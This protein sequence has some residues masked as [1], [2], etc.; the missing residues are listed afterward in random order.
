VQACS[1]IYIGILFK[2]FNG[3]YRIDRF[4]CK[5]EKIINLLSKL[6]DQ[7]VLFVLQYDKMELLAVHR[8]GGY[9]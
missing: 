8:T 1:P 5:N 3:L 7:R 6:I 9:W 4:D 2:L